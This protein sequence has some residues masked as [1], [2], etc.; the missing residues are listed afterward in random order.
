[1]PLDYL[2]GRYN[3]KERSIPLAPRPTYVTHVLSE[4]PTVLNSPVFRLIMAVQRFTTKL[5]VVSVFLKLTIVFPALLSR[6]IPQFPRAYASREPKHSY[7]AIVEIPYLE[8]G[9]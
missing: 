5:S 9:S 1:M 4:V 8:D 2:M 3:P 7:P 6:P